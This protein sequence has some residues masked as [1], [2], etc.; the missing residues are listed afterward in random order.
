VALQAA[1]AN[2]GTGADRKAIPLELGTRYPVRAVATNPRPPASRLATVPQASNLTVE[3]DGERHAFQTDA[4]VIDPQYAAYDTAPTIRLEGAHLFNEFANASVTLGGPALFEA[5]PETDGVRLYV[6]DGDLNLT[7]S[8]TKSVSVSRLEGPRVARVHDTATITIPTRAPDRWV[9]ALRGQDDADQVSTSDRAVR[10]TTTVDRIT[11]VRIG[12]GDDHGPPQ[13]DEFGTSASRTAKPYALSW[14]AT[15]AT[16]APG[17]TTTL[18]ATRDAA[19]EGANATVAYSDPADV[20]T[21][22]PETATFADGSASIPV[23]VAADARAG[24]TI[25]VYVTSGGTTATATVTVTV[26]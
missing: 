12:I 15:N 21:A 4:L 22:I 17:K 8:R 5:G 2:V 23:T 1:I 13:L 9:A 20:V 14:A 18:T 7:T 6:L 19:I 10:F 25:E 16:V 3:I 11:V 24:T 26:T